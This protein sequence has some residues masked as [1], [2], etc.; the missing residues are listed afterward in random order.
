[1]PLSLAASS[2]YVNAQYGNT[3]VLVTHNEAV[4]YMADQVIT[5]RDGKIRT[6]LRNEHKLSAMELE[7]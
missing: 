1:M 6:D 5:L 2:A 4:R 3:V 7:W